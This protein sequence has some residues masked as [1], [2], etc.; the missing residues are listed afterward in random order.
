MKNGPRSPSVIAGR[1]WIGSTQALWLAGS[2]ANE[3]AVAL[4]NEAAVAVVRLKSKRQDRGRVDAASIFA[5][6]ADRVP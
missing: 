5:P 1:F 6:R 3:A 2:L 4:A